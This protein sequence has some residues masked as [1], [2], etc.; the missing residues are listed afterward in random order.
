MYGP[1]WRRAGDYSGGIEVE[2]NA[3]VRF[4]ASWRWNGEPF[5]TAAKEKTRQGTT[6]PKCRGTFH[7]RR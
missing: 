2:H 6:V 3:E 1:K 7:D 4:L 5:V